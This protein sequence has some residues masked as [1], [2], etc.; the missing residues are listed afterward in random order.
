[1]KPLMRVPS[2]GLVRNLLGAAELHRAEPLVV[3][4]REPAVALLVERVHGFRRF[5]DAVE[6]RD[7]FLAADIERAGFATSVDQA[8]DLVV[9]GL[10]AR[11]MLVAIV[12]DQEVDRAAV[13]RPHGR[14]HVAIERARQDARLAAFRGHDGQVVRRVVNEFRIAGGDEREL[15]AIGTPARR[16]HRRHVAAVAL[17]FR[18]QLRRCAGLRR[19][20]VQAE[21]AAA[22]RILAAVAEERDLLAVRRPRRPALGVA[23]RRQDF[24]FAAGDVEYIDVL[25]LLAEITGFVLFEIVAIDDDRRRRLVFLAFL[26]LVRILVGDD[27]RESLAVGRPGV[28][29]HV[30][31]ETGERA[32]FAAR[33]IEQPHLLRLLVA[34][35]RGEERNV[36]AVRAPARRV[37]AVLRLSE[38]Q[39]P[40]AVP[41][42]HPQMRHAL[43]FDR[44]GAA[45][46]VRNPLA[47]GRDLRIVDLAQG[48]D[49]IRRQRASLG[50]TGNR[51][52]E[53]GRE[54]QCKC[55]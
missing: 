55:S 23:A 4:M 52:R 7:A 2:L 19:H 34:A 38:L 54:Q 16:R 15:A 28:V 53:Q 22:I 47:V 43:V 36:L 3:V 48:V 20:D 46:R 14:D 35:A 32:C 50:R 5:D 10:D 26:L 49:V 40:A 31:V 42:R 27:Q 51:R 33:A 17:K 24:R 9:A 44:I 11:E 37:L 39:L 18:E 21:L 12:L 6:H 30:A 41:A 25:P 1:M 8:L 29:D 13:A 45:H